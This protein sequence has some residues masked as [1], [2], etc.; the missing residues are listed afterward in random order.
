MGYFEKVDAQVSD[1][2]KGKLLTFVVQENPTIQEVNIKGN[3][4]IKEKDILAAIATKPY[5]VL[6]KN[7]INEDVQKILKLYQ[8]KGFFNA[9]VTTDITYPR[10]PRNAVVTFNIQEKGRVYIEE[11]SFAGNEHFSDRKLRG[12]MQTKEKSIFLSWFTDRGILQK[13]ILD[14]D[15]DRLTVYYHD[16]GFMDAKVGTPDVSFR[17]DG[18]YI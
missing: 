16:R 5:T 17:K 3:K 15:V 2:P 10:D 8:Q 9:D 13:D 6:E 4:K 14:T 7:I 18:I 12:V 11:I 1:T